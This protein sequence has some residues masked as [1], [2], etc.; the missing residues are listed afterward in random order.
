MV[1]HKI[2]TVTGL[3]EALRAFLDSKGHDMG[4]FVIYADKSGHISHGIQGNG[5]D[6]SGN[7]YYIPGKVL[8][9]FEDVTKLG[10]VT[11]T[12]LLNVSEK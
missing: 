10:A 3:V 6:N 9:S 1:E 12:K 8:C 2:D 11:T 5:S 4:Y 7:D